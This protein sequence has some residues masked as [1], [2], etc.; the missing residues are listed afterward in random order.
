MLNTA[1][2]IV[3]AVLAAVVFNNFQRGT[4]GQWFQAKFM[5]RAAPAGEGQ[6]LLGSR[7]GTGGTT[8]G[9]DSSGS[10]TDSIASGPPSGR[11]ESWRGVTLDANAMTSYKA[12]VNAAAADGVTLIGGSSYRSRAA[13]EALRRSHG[14]GGAKVYDHSCKGN[15]PTAVPGTSNHE[16]GLAVDFKGIPQ[17]ADRSNKAFAWLQD[18][19][20]TYGWENFKKEG[21]HWSTGPRAGS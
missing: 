12:M 4:L 1:S 19:A 3:M 5:G 7:F 9:T 6:Q 10:G 13:Q 20:P 17:H 15:P 21:W 8:G 16:K 18:H 2:G 11:L 14:C